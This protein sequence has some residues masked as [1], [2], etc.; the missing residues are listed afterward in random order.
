MWIEI[1]A[2]EYKLAEL[3]NSDSIKRIINCRNSLTLIYDLGGTD[4]VTESFKCPADLLNRFR[5]IKAMLIKSPVIE[6]TD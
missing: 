1:P 3:I 2:T 6:R 4:C 5:E